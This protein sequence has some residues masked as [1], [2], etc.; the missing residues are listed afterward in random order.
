MFPF[1]DGGFHRPVYLLLFTA[2][3][4]ASPAHAQQSQG[5]D[6]PLLRGSAAPED[7]RAYRSPAGSAIPAY[8]NA[9]QSAP[10]PIYDSGALAPNYIKPRPKTDKRARYS[11]RRPIAAKKLPATEP[12]RTAPASVR[13]RQSSAPGVDADPPPPN[14]A[15]PAQPAPKRKP[16][17]DPDPYAPLGVNIGNVNVKPFLDVQAGYDTNPRRTPTKEGSPLLRGG[18]GFTAQSDWSR[19]EFTAEAQGSI[20]ASRKF[21]TRI[22]LKARA[23]RIFV[24]TSCATRSPISNCA[25]RWRRSV[26]VRPTCRAPRS[27]SPRSRAMAQPR[28]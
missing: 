14:Y 11:G 5:G 3:A 13:A 25:A 12:Y 20:W 21:L 10:E 6:G 7:P 9:R 23:R 28:A 24:S 19:H 18:L 1:A 16:R 2:L 22:A 4:A 17:V 8:G 15:L 27:T 26:P